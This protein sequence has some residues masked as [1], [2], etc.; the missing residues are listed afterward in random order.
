MKK[1]NETLENMDFY[2]EIQES[3]WTFNAAS[4]DQIK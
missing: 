3:H 4:Y 1:Q 2:C